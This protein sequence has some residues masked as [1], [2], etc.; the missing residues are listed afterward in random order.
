MYESILKQYIHVNKSHLNVL[1]QQLS[2][3]MNDELNSNV[4]TTCRCISYNV[5]LYSLLLYNVCGLY[6]SCCKQQRIWQRSAG[7]DTQLC[8]ISHVLWST[9]PLPSRHRSRSRRSSHYVHVA[10]Q[11]AAILGWKPFQVS[12]CRS[13]PPCRYAALLYLA[14]ANDT[15]ARNLH[16]RLLAQ[17]F[18]MQICVLL[19]DNGN[20]SVVLNS[21]QN[22][23]GH[24]GRSSQ[25]ISWLLLAVFTV[26]M[27]QRTVSK[28][29]NWRKT[30]G[31]PDQAEVPPGHRTVTTEY[32]CNLTKLTLSCTS[33]LLQVSCE[34]AIGIKP[35][36][37]TVQQ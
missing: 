14:H 27:T 22:N 33:R 36:I 4:G 21:T 30:A 19:R 15:H 18:F 17:K 11:Y 1:T 24:S 28:T 5:A 7:P 10:Y 29:N 34:Y 2:Y 12:A 3:L 8:Q 16:R 13:S 25:S 32:L 9:G 37:H 6:C 35:A 20:D 31:R 23:I 26:Q